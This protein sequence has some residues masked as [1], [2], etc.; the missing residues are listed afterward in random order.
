M[1]HTQALESALSGAACGY[2]D[3]TQD[4]NARAEG[5]V[6]QPIISGSYAHLKTIEKLSLEVEQLRNSTTQNTSRYG[7]A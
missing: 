4:T 2:N 7:D 3:S 5:I 6:S 1:D